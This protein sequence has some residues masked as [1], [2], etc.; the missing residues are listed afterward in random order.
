MGTDETGRSFVNNVESF[1][2]E[3][4]FTPEENL[5]RLQVLHLARI[6]LHIDDVDDEIEAELTMRWSFR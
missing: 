5:G 3:C 1:T 4:A 2:K 6:D